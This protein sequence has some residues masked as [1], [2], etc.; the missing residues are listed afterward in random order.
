[1]FPAT[2]IQRHASA[3]PY[4]CCRG[5]FQTGPYSD[6]FAPWGPNF[7][8]QPVGLDNPAS[9]QAPFAGPEGKSS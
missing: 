5:G 9:L 6:L 3:C 7:Q 8:T 2:L 1:M 4:K